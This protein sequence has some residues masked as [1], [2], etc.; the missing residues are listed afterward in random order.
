[1]TTLKELNALPSIQD[2]TADLVR[3]LIGEYKVHGKPLDVEKED[4]IKMFNRVDWIVN[5]VGRVMDVS[6]KLDPETTTFR[7]D[8]GEDNRVRVRFIDLNGTTLYTVACA[9]KLPLK[10][11]SEYVVEN[12]SGEV[13]TRGNKWNVV[14]AFFAPEK[15][16]VVRQAA[17][18]VKKEK[19][20]KAAK[21]VKEKRVKAVKNPIPAV[22]PE[23]DVIAEANAIINDDVPPAELG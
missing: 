22:A 19:K 6:G 1:M 21:V 3:E 10:C 20:A 18:P 8:R 13:V 12:A 5:R 7:I 14:S 15:E 23:T 2:F 9:G 16:K 4:P 11:G 17:A